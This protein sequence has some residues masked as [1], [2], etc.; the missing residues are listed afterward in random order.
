MN[1]KRILCSTLAIVTML[2]SIVNKMPTIAAT[3][4]VTFKKEL[5]VDLSNC[6]L[7]IGDDVRKFFGN[8]TTVLNAAKSWESN[9]LSFTLRWKSATTT[10]KFTACCMMSKLD[11]NVSGRT[12]FFSDYLGHVDPDVNYWHYTFVL[13]NNTLQPSSL[14]GTIAHEIGHVMGLRHRNDMPISIMCQGGYG[15]TAVV[16]CATDKGC[17][18]AKYKNR[19]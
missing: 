2:A 14:N 4:P 18:S 17:L 16:P 1:F 19:N 11:Y 13:F 9:K 10:D 12:V 6:K 3:E 8:N 5:A 7:V 15:R